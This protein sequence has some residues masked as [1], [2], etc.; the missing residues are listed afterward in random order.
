MSDLN[1]M[2]AG[3]LVIDAIKNATNNPQILRK[4]KARLNK[5]KTQPNNILDRGYRDY[6]YM[7]FN[8][9]EGRERASIVNSR[10]KGMSPALLEQLYPSNHTIADNYFDRI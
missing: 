5:G 9:P 6:G 8:S 4:L 10:L 1:L 7:I 3:G 2:E